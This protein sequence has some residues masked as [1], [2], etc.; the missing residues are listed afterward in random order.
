MQQLVKRLGRLELLATQLLLEDGR[1]LGAHVDPHLVEQGDGAD[2]EAEVLQGAIEHLHRFAFQHQARRLVHV[3]GQDAVH[4]ETRLV[5]DHYGGLALGPGEGQGGG[6]RLGAG[7]RVG[8]DLGERHLVHRAEVVQT[9]Y[10]VRAGGPFGN[11][12]DGQGRG[13]GGKHGM[14][15]ALALHVLHHLMLEVD[16]LEYR[17]HHQVHPVE[18]RVV[19]GAGQPAH[20]LF[21]LAAQDLA[22]LEL[23]GQQ[24]MAVAHGVADPGARHILDPHRHP[25]L[26]GGDIGDAASHQAAPQHGGMAHLARL[27]PLIVHLLLHLGGGEEEGAQGGGL[28]R[29]HQ[30]AKVAGFGGKAGLD[31]LFHADAHHVQDALRRRIVATG[32]GHDSLA[33]LIEQHL[34]PDPAGLQQLAL[35]V[36]LQGVTGLALVGQLDGSLEQDG[37]RD[38]LVHQPQFARLLGPDLLAGQHQ[39]QRLGHPDEARQ[40]LGTA[41]ARQQAQLHLGHPQH[42]LAMVTRDPAMAGERQL[43]PPAEA[44]AMNGGDHRDA[45]LLDLGEHLLPFPGQDLGILGAGAGIQHADVGPGDEGVLLA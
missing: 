43:Q 12:V 13:V 36:P 42:R 27:G 9:H 4:V 35:Q 15:A 37:G 6:H 30:L 11:P 8:D 23:L 39:I 20:L 14:F 34:A 40:T 21:Q 24:I 17:L 25:R 18:T 3:G 28:R 1:D 31:P 19:Q 5:L 26:G 16:I 41:G 7:T 32:L 45:E 2:R 38:H 33:G 22:A 10:L 44:G 29:H